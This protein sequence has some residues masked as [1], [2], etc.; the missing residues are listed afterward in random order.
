M[1]RSWL[2]QRLNKPLNGRGILG[3]DNPFAFGGGLHNGGLSSQAMDLLRGVFSFD[4]MGSAEF[5]FGAVPEALDG[6]AKSARSLAAG[7]LDIPLAEVAPHW[8]ERKAK[9][10]PEGSGAVYYLARREDA[11]EVEQ[12]IRQWAREGFRAHLKESTHLESTLR[13]HNEWDGRTVGW[14]EL[15]NGFFFFT[16]HDMWAKT[17]DLFGVATD[18]AVSA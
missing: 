5:E 16:D 7:S 10:T 4:Y 13:P 14:L 12:R 18:E 8:S 17:C 1:Q 11:T 2:I 9:T 15:D 3:P 6:L